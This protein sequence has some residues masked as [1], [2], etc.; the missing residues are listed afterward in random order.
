MGLIDLK[1]RGQQNYGPCGEYRVELLEFLG[2]TRILWQC[3]FL[4][5]TL[6]PPP[7]PYKYSCDLPILKPFT[8]SRL[9]SAL[10]PVK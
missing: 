2:A 7:F 5:L 1:S 8:S 4:T 9:Q 3:P 10:C 6:L